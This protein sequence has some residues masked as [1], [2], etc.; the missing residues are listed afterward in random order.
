VG[1]EG[2]K[3]GEARR[4]MGTQKENNGTCARA[5]G[6]SYCRGTVLEFFIFFELLFLEC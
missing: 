1:E 5:V 3:K 4:N 2:G 6:L